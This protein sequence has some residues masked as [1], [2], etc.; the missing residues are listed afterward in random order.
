MSVKCFQGTIFFQPFVLHRTGEFPYKTPLV[1]RLIDSHEQWQLETNS[2][3]NKM[4]NNV[5]PIHS[6]LN[7]IIYSFSNI[8]FYLHFNSSIFI[9]N[10]NQGIYIY[11][12]MP[13]EL[14]SKKIGWKEPYGE[15]LYTYPYRI[16]DLV[17][18]STLCTNVSRI[19]PQSPWRWLHRSR[20]AKMPK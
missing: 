17:S 16:I 3:R 7:Y 8:N 12:C 2:E 19:N 6:I 11:S 5:L 18:S 4:T 20:V 1:G 14:W 13:I 15:L 10:I 9:R